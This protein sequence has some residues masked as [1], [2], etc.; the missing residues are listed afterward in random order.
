MASRRSE[1]CNCPL[2]L[3][4]CCC[5]SRHLRAQSCMA[6]P[7][8]MGS[9]KGTSSNLVC[10]GVFGSFVATLVLRVTVFKI[11]VALPLFPFYCLWLSTLV[12]RLNSFVFFCSL[13][14]AASKQP[15]PAPACHRR[16]RMHAT[17]AYRCSGIACENSRTCVS[18]SRCACNCGVFF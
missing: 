6:S 15:Q 17:L 5:C 10:C 9:S 3:H 8:E 14:H 18:L 4:Y 1:W 16:E 11:F 13:P 7:L 12:L 2:R